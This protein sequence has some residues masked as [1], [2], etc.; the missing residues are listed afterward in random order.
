[1]ELFDELVE[2]EVAIIAPY[3]NSLLEFCLAVSMHALCIHT[4]TYTLMCAEYSHM[5]AHKHTF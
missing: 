1:M 3:L 5:Y 2:C 4:R